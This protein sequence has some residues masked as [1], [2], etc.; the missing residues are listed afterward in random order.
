MRK[1]EYGVLALA[2]SVFPGAAAPSERRAADA[3]AAPLAKVE[4]LR[5]RADKDSS[6]LL[7]ALCAVL[8]DDAGTPQEVITSVLA[9]Q[10]LD[11]PRSKSERI[12]RDAV[13][14]KLESE[15]GSASPDTLGRIL[16]LAAALDADV[17]V[18]TPAVETFLT[19]FDDR[20]RISQESYA[21][22]VA[23]V[24]SGL[25]GGRDLRW[26]IRIAL[27][28]ARS[29]RRAGKDVRREIES[30]LE[31]AATDRRVTRDVVRDL[32]RSFFV[33]PA[34]AHEPRRG[35][36]STGAREALAR[37]IEALSDYQFYVNLLP[38]TDPDRVAF[39]ESQKRLSASYVEALTTCSSAAASGG[40]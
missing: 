37:E 35:A 14:C 12:L 15:S 32:E 13:T 34:S 4:K 17:V 8:L 7:K 3:C 26:T 27:D 6:A 20:S 10:T 31:A 19:A 24:R 33:M 40:R 22:A 11:L 18:P 9:D 21:A 23:L 5:S 30:A 39:I 28:V 36:C 1:L 16:L 38:A 29:L 2:L 25:D